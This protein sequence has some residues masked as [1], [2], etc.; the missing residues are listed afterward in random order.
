MIHS[1]S[2]IKWVYL[3]ENP[4]N[5]DCLA[6]KA[7]G[8]DPDR[9]MEIVNTYVDR[10]RL[11]EQEL[12]GKLEDFYNVFKWMLPNQSGARSAKFID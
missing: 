7:D 11:Y 5:M 6:F 1:G 3:R 4:Y 2:K 9:I 8:T 10:K 12:K